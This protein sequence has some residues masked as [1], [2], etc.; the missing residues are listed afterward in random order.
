MIR[1]ACLIWFALA[2]ATWATQDAWPALFDVQGVAVDDV[3]NIRAAPNA[4]APII[5]QLR[6]DATDVEVISPNSRHSW[7]LINSGEETGWVSLAYL[8]RQPRQWL[9][10]FPDVRACY[11]TEPFWSLGRDGQGALTWDE[12]GLS[13]SGTET[14]TWSSGN[15]RDRH[16]FSGRFDGT[17][18]REVFAVLSLQSCRDGMSDRLFGISVD[19]LIGDLEGAEMLSGCCSLQSR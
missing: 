3:L 5:G 19:L 2:S 13:T 15:R 14:Q 12:P 7:G 9:G 4:E 10:S 17:G 6:H 16:A 8:V 1:F 18:P 11:G